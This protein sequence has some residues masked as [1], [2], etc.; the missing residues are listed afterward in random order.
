MEVACNIVHEHRILSQDKTYTNH[1]DFMP[2]LG[3]SAIQTR[4]S[5]LLDCQQEI[6]LIIEEK[7]PK[8]MTCEEYIRRYAAPY[9]DYLLDNALIATA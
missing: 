3:P 9:A 7:K 8:W 5:W 6:S 1:S 4:I 2:K